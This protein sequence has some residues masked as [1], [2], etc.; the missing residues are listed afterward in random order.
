MMYFNEIEKA[1]HG[2]M[3]ETDPVKWYRATARALDAA[4]E[5]K[6]MAVEIELICADAAKRG[7]YK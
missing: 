5:G 7:R 2:A 1:L 3:G 4:R 6:L